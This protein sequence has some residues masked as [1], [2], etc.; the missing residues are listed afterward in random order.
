MK[1]VGQTGCFTA[2]TVVAVEKGYKKIEDVKVGDKVWSKNIKTG[3]IKLKKVVRLY[4]H[5]A[6]YIVHLKINGN[7]IK[8]TINHPYFYKEYNPKDC[9]SSRGKIKDFEF[10]LKDGYKQKD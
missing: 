4:K 3:K 1:K 7:E 2:G 6:N 9:I 5:K 10:H 8:T